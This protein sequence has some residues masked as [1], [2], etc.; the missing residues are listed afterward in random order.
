MKFTV[1]NFYAFKIW[2]GS[3]KPEQSKKIDTEENLRN[4]NVFHSGV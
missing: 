2:K 4:H 3:S 1:Q